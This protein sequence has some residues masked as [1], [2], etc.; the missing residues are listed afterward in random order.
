MCCN[1][2][3]TQE[4]GRR[5]KINKDQTMHEILN[6]YEGSTEFYFWRSWSNKDL[7][8]IALNFMDFFFFSSIR[9]QSAAAVSNCFLSICLHILFHTRE[10]LK[11]S[12]EEVGRNW[13]T[14]KS[15][16]LKRPFC[17]WWQIY[18]PGEISLDMVEVPGSFIQI[19]KNLLMTYDK[20]PC[21]RE[22]YSGILVYI[23]MFF[24]DEIC[25]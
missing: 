7:K 10:A 12:G 8:K 11:R 19:N 17:E 13:C 24:S 18:L 16:A 2:H 21:K 20:L 6:D 14:T 22:S 9:R 1:L 4:H 25:K 5:K 23:E 15:M 3:T